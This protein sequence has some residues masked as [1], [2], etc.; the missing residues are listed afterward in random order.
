MNR[1]TQNGSGRLY[2]YRRKDIPV[3]GTVK[4]FC[5]ENEFYSFVDNTGKRDR[6]LEETFSKLETVWALRVNRLLSVKDT[7]ALT[8]EERVDLAFFLAFQR[9]RGRR[10]REHLKSFYDAS[11]KM[12]MR[13]HASSEESLKRSFLEAGI[14]LSDREIKEMRDDILDDRLRVEYPEAYWLQQSMELALQS[15]PHY[16]AKTYWQLAKVEYP[17]VLIT[18]DN[19]VAILW[20]PDL[21]RFYG[22]GIANGVICLPLAPD[23]A[24]ILHDNDNLVEYSK[25][26]S[27][28]KVKMI[29]DH[30]M[31]YAYR[32]VFSHLYLADISR[33]FRQTKEGAGERVAVAGPPSLIP[34]EYRNPDVEAEETD[35]ILWF[36]AP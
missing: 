29:N 35:S 32:F 30:L 2:A 31:F 9:T 3:L 27:K 19:P 8:E 26:L 36:K 13:L 22:V 11:D 14:D 25:S 1:F 17:N 21:P 10:F 24:L 33:E 16:H 28:T 6:V 15:F 34:I 23:T 20:P 4:D 7:A 5:G 18:S 12:L